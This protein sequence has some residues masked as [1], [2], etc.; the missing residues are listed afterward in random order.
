MWQG[1]YIFKCV[2]EKGDYELADYDG[3]HLSEPKNGIYL[4]KYYS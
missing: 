1:P 4:N 3:I 2:L